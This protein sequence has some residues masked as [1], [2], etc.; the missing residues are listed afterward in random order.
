MPC[1]HRSVPLSTHLSPLLAALPPAAGQHQAGPKATSAA[2]GAVAEPHRFVLSCLVLTHNID[3][4]PPACYC[5][6][7]SNPSLSMAYLT[8]S[9]ISPVGHGWDFQRRPLGSRPLGDLV[10]NSQPLLKTH[11]T[12]VEINCR[13]CTQADCSRFITIPVK[14]YLSHSLS[15]S[16]HSFPL[17]S[18]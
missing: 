1:V 16:S 5:P 15:H 12:A 9:S 13:F 11:R 18:P 8:W 17:R 4:Y 2:Q 6:S 10:N 3:C 14:C 7:Q